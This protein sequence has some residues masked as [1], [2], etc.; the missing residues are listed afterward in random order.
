M[1]VWRLLRERTFGI[2]EGRSIDEW[3]AAARIAGFTG[4]LWR[5]APRGAE[6]LDQLR[7]RTAEFFDVRLF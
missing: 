7:A 4:D 1:R 3:N 6:S 5:Y 2:G